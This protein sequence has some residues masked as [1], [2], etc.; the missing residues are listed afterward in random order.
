MSECIV[1]KKELSDIEINLNMD[2]HS[3]CSPTVI[4]EA[5]KLLNE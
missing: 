2:F 3:G 4:K 1:C 5:W